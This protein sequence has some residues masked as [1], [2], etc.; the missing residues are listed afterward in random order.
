MPAARTRISV[1]TGAWRAAE[2]RC[3]NLGSV[4]SLTLSTATWISTVWSWRSA[5]KRERWGPIKAILLEEA[6]SGV[7]VL[8]RLKVNVGR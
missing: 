5:H 7:A 1:T 2:A 8:Q 3:S 6:A 4:L